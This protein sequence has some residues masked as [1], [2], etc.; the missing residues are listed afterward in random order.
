[1][2]ILTLVRHQ[3]Y[4]SELRLR[5]INPHAELFGSSALRY[6]PKASIDFAITLL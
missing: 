6:E 3:F 2:L 4:E 1:M 5:S